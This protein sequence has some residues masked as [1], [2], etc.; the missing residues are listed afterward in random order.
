M[1]LTETRSVIDVVN[2]IINELEIFSESPTQVFQS[3]GVQMRKRYRRSRRARWL[4]M[5]N[6]GFS[7]AR[8]ERRWTI[9]SVS[10]SLVRIPFPNSPR[11]PSTEVLVHARSA[12]A[13]MRIHN[14]RFPTARAFVRIASRQRSVLGIVGRLFRMLSDACRHNASR[15]SPR[16]KR[17]FCL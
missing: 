11:Y 8:P 16:G 15:N 1:V 12:M 3:A 14:Q 7:G 17:G 5:N 2:R 10:Y 4:Y 6:D 13:K 9:A